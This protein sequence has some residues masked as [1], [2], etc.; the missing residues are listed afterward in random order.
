[1]KNFSRCIGISTLCAVLFLGFA[2]HAS[3]GD[4]ST[5]SMITGTTITYT[6]SLLSYLNAQEN[7]INSLFTTT[8][9]NVYSAF[10]K[11]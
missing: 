4:A 6:G 3:T 1:M 8:Y 10:T 7:N 2:T 11:T 5:G 9:G